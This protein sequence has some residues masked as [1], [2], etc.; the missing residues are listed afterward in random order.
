MAC[1]CKA[2]T[3]KIKKL[4]D[5]AIVP[6]YGK[7]GDAGAD[8]YLTEVVRLPPHARALGKTGIAIELPIGYEAQIRSRS[9]TSLK[10]GVII[11]NSPG[12][13]DE[14]YRGEIGLVLYNSSDVLV[15]LEV[16]ERVAQMVI[17]PVEQANFEIVEE[18]SDSDRG[19]GGFGSTG[20]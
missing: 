19:S 5:N 9:G 1:R 18:L 3:V 20:S 2:F 13:I 16:G 12:T 7:E 8:L 17:K 14:G 15:H 4:T 10:K 11:L 6:T